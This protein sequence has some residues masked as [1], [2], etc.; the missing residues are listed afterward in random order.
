MLQIVTYRK[1]EGKSLPLGI[2]FGAAVDNDSPGAI[3]DFCLSHRLTCK[4]LAVTGDNFL[5][6]QNVLFCFASLVLAVVAFCF[7][8]MRRC[9]C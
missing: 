3:A 7:T 9:C 2:V 1:G 4:A 5:S 8:L 6:S